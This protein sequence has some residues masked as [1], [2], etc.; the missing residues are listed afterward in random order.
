MA[1]SLH[2]SLVLK[3]TRS[4][5]IVSAIPRLDK[6]PQYSNTSRAAMS[7]IGPKPERP[8]FRLSLTKDIP[9]YDYERRYVVKKARRVVAGELPLWHTRRKYFN[10]TTI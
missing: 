2:S 9:D 1:D 10:K 7:I 5:D 3:I 6:L 4:N 8:V